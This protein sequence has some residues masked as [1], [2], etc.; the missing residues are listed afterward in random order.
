MFEKTFGEM[1][2]QLG[3]TTWLASDAYTLADIEITPYVERIDRLG[4]KGMWENRP[5]VADWQVHRL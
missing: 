3:R 1:E 2:A 5:R 4:L